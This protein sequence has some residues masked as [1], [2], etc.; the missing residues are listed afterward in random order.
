[1]LK[2][3]LEFFTGHKETDWTQADKEACVKLLVLIMYSDDKLSDEEDQ[4]IHKQIALF[5]WKGVHNEDY[6]LHESIRAVRNLSNNPQ[7]V[8]NFISDISSSINESEVKDKIISLCDELTKADGE[9]SPKEV[10]LVNQIKSSL[11]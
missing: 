7:G 11:A 6:F 2:T 10:E 4:L 3:I 5:D 8:Q 1:M 9:V